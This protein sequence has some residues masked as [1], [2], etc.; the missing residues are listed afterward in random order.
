MC[1]RDRINIDIKI[2]IKRKL[3]IYNPLDGSFAKLLIEFKIPDL[4]R[5]VPLILNEKVVIDKIIVHS[6]NEFL[7]CNTITVCSSAVKQNHGINETFSTGSQ[8]QKPPQ[9]SS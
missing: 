6:L 4:T 2:R 8:N 7:F 1:I 9:P 3:N 5:K